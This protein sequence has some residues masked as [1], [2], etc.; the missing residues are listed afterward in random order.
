MIWLHNAT[1]N[2][3]VGVNSLDGYGED[4]AEIEPSPG[5]GWWW[6]NEAGAWQPIVQRIWPLRLFLTELFTPAEFLGIR[7]WQ[8]P[9]APTPDDLLFLWAREV[10]LTLADVNLDDPN[11]G[12]ALTM[13]V[14][15]GLLSEARAAQ[16][17][18]GAFPE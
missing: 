8:P 11:T 6:N 17:L 9:A 1:I 13:C 18:A 10:I 4:W 15:R 7:L 2:E 5:P 16:V 14:S 12:A 3:T